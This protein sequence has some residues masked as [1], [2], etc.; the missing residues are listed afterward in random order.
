[1]EDNEKDDIID[2]DDD[3]KLIELMG[4]IFSD[5]D[6]TEDGV[7][8]KSILDKRS[9]KVG[10]PGR[11]AFDFEVE[12]PGNTGLTVSSTD[13]GTKA[14]GEIPP[15][16]TSALELPELVR[17]DILNVLKSVPRVGHVMAVSIVD[18]GFDNYYKLSTLEESDLKHIPGLGIDMAVKLV[19]RLRKEYP[20]KVK[21]EEN[22]EKEPVVPVEKVE[23]KVVPELKE[24]IEE[25][26]EETSEE[27]DTQEI[28]AEE[29]TSADGEETTVDSEEKPAEEG[30]EK[31][32][33]EKGG[34][35]DKIKGL[36]TRKKTAPETEEKEGEK[37]DGKAEALSEDGVTESDGSDDKE[38]ST[39]ETADIR[40]LSDEITPELTTPL[41]EEVLSIK[42][43]AIHTSNQQIDGEKKEYLQL[44]EVN[45]EGDGGTDDTVAPVITGNESVSPVRVYMTILDVEEDVA[46]NLH[47][48]GYRNLQELKEAI[49]EDLV[50]VEGVNP[51]MARKIYAKLH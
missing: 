38:A 5:E 21:K 26:K 15:V 37:E 32:E 39:G 14:L 19:A 25:T 8:G 46:E 29:V 10:E 24:E 35:W 31:E 18:G 20:T 40:D 49:P 36:F 2:D 4:D 48:A 7:D 43:E 33:K 42:D 13:R 11:R 1:M 27:D 22:M 6:A 30:K 41:K 34:V 23:E 16:E 51:T 44:K 3:E 12:S 47:S 50:Y 45:E 17:E 9:E 28:P